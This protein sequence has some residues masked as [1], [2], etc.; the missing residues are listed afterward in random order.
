MDN[1]RQDS[2]QD[3]MDTESGTAAEGGYPEE[4]PGGEGGGASGGTDSSGSSGTDDGK[5][6][7]GGSATGNPGAAG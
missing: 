1:E 7:Q 5:D 4:E 6:R 3:Q 2:S